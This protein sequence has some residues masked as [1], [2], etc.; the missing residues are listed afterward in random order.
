MH[1]VECFGHIQNSE[2]E[3]KDLEKSAR[4][5]AEAKRR[6]SM[7]QHPH[8][9]FSII[10]LEILL[11]LYNLQLGVSNIATNILGRCEVCDGNFDIKRERSKFHEPC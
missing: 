8:Y 3:A 4:K 1:F 9:K 11:V 7:R 10:N 2:L 5:N 6:H